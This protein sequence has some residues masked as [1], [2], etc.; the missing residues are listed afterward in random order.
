MEDS[1]KEV[2][3]HKSENDLKAGSHK[4]ENDLTLQD[5]S[6]DEPKDNRSDRSLFIGFIVIVLI[7]GA[8]F[9]IR[10]FLKDTSPK[11]IDDMHNLNL[12][13]ELKESQGYVYNG[14]SFIN[15]SGFWYTEMKSTT[16]KTLYAIDFR[17]GPK[18]VENVEMFGKFDVD[19]FNNATEAYVTFDPTRFEE[20]T[21][22]TVPVGDLDQHLIKVFKKMPIAACVKNET[23]ECYERPIVDCSSED[24][25]FYFLEAE[26]PSIVF[27]D[28]CITI[29]GKEFDIVRAVDKLLLKFYNII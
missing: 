25:V 28:N 17:Y 15:V 8:I 7:L 22:L 6:K 20:Y 1:K 21:F 4:S 18:Q 13:G 12:E 14:F 11:T 3:S 24:L 5:E 23:K 9:G 16:G 2:K 26:E 19:F 10:F 27:D 29:K